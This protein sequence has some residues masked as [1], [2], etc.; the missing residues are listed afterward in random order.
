LPVLVPHVSIMPAA[1]AQLWPSLAD[2]PEDF[3]LYGGTAL[4]L[5]LG[6]RASADFDFFSPEPFVPTDLLV[7]LAWLGRVTVNEAAPSSLVV[8]TEDGVN[9]AFF[10]AM[11]LQSVAEPSIVEANGIVVASL[12][13]LAGTKAKALL[14]RAEW[15][16]YADIAALLRAG[17]T[18]PEIIG[19]AVTIFEPIIAF[20]AAVFLRSLA[21]F[22]DGTV[23]DLPGDIQRELEAAVA[24]VV[25]EDIPVVAPF[26]SSILP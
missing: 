23:R 24:S 18:L 16:D 11:A 6:H 7:D 20:P 19:Y 21:W 3:V 12:F 4:A 2:V 13:D 26:S 22:E 10:G 14:D 8:T 1:Q 15:R 9:L 25:P 17:I 5:R